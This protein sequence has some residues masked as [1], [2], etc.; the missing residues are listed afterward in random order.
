MKIETTIKD[1]IRNS[2]PIS[3]SR[4]MEICL[5]DDKN[6]YYTSNEVF[7]GKG[8]FITSPEVSQT[9]GELIGLWAFSFYQQFLSG[10]RL[11]ITELGSGRGTLLKDAI[12]AIYTVTNKQID[13]DITILEKSQRLVT[14]Q[15][16][17]LRNNNVRWI[18]N[19]KN[20]S[21]E[22]QILIA[23]EFFDALPINQYVK[24]NEGWH[25]KRISIKNDKLCFTLDK[26]IWVPNDSIFSNFEIGDTLEYSEPG[27][28]IFSNICNHLFKY[29]GVLLVIDYG[30]TSGVGDTLQAVNNHEIRSVL[31]TPGQSDL[32]SHV[33]F[34]LLKEIANK[35]NLYVSPLVDQ[36]RFLL[37]LGIEERLR[38]LT[39]N[40]CSSKA[41][42]VA[43]EI[44]RLIDPG[45]MGTLFKVIA[46]TKN[47]K[48]LEG[49]NQYA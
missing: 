8:D 17:N 9:F 22:P 13:L 4:Y 19:I 44:K 27:V 1:L 33:N 47:K 46:I 2:G 43:S 10:N 42:K 32:S 30:N 6:G 5:W 37:K 20:L 26:K 45:K 16:E 23:N 49:L 41:E 3:I 29:D 28:T 48:H 39:K 31:E 40:L 24:G 21:S 14:L 18:S 34:N 12:R 15:K 7:G 36:Q 11:C 38:S 35:K 25:E